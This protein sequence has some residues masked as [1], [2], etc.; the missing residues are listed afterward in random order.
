MDVKL[1]K[2]FGAIGTLL[3][4]IWVYY[5]VQ[6]VYSPFAWIFVIAASFLIAAILVWLREQLNS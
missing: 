3:G 6:Y 2:E 1:V 5:K 4:L